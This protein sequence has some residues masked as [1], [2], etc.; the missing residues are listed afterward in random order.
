MVAAHG[1]AH[2]LDFGE[3]LKAVFAALT[4]SARAFY[5][6]KRLTQVAHVLTVD[7]HHASFN[8]AG[9]AMCLA[10]V[11]GPDVGGQAV[12]GVIGQA[13]RFGF[14]LELDQAHHRAKDFFLG[15][16]HLVVDVGKYGRL[17]ELAFGQVSRQIGRALQATGE[18]AGAFLD[19]DLD[20]AGDLVVVRLGDH[21]ADLGFRVGRVA[22]NQAFGAGGEF[23]D[24][25]VVDG[26]LDEDAAAGGAAFAV[27]REDGE[28]R[29]IQRAL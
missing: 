11:L 25:L 13:Q 14:V 9:Q 21:R 29:R 18:Q 15:D 23:G 1:N 17:D 3:Y 28:Q 12:F 22:D 4:A 19:A 7:E 20:V 6:T 24:E 8:A 27:Q 2:V 26:F 5:T 16:A 10:D